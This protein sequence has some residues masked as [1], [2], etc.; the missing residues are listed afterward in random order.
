MPTSP[1]TKVVEHLRKTVLWQEEDHLSDGQLLDRF[2]EMRDHAAFAALVRRHGP[3]VWGVCL[4]IVGHADD[5]EDA[6]QAAFLILV[7]KAAAVKP[8]EAVGN[9]LYGVAA[10]AALKA[11]TA[12]ARVRAKE[13]Q[14]IGMPDPAQVQHDDRE[15]LLRLLD[16]ELGVLPDKYRLPVVLCDLEGRTRKEV[17][18]QLKIPEGT[19]SS[20]LTTAHQKLAKRLARNGLA[21]SGASLAC[22]LA[23]NAASASVPPA[24]VSATINAATLVAAGTGVVAG[25]VSTKVAALTEGVLKTMLLTKLK[26]VAAVLLVVGMFASGAGGLLTYKFATAQQGQSAETKKGQGAEAKKQEEQR[27]LEQAELEGTWSLISFEIN[28]K[29]QPLSW[30]RHEWTFKD[31]KAELRRDGQENE[32]PADRF[33][34]ESDSRFPVRPKRRPNEN[35]PE[36]TQFLR[37]TV[38]PSKSPKELN[39]SYDDS[40]KMLYVYK[41]EKDTL[42]LVVLSDTSVRPEG[43][44]LKDALPS[45]SREEV[46]VEVYERKRIPRAAEPAWGDAVD[47]VRYGISLSNA[48]A[49]I[50]LG[51]EIQFAF[52]VQNKNAK[53]VKLAPFAMYGW[54]AKWPLT[55]D[56]VPIFTNANGK[57]IVG[58]WNTNKKESSDELAL[59]AGETRELG[60][61]GWH[62][63]PLRL[64]GVDLKPGKY[65]VHFERLLV[66]TP[67][68]TGK[69]DIEV[70]EPV[71]DNLPAN[72]TAWGQAVEGIEYGLELKDKRK[73]YRVG[74]TASFILKARNVAGKRASFEYGVNLETPSIFFG[75]PLPTVIDAAGKEVEVS[76]IGQWGANENTRTV[77]LSAGQVVVV[78]E[79][80]FVIGRAESAYVDAGPGTY[81]VRYDSFYPYKS[82]QQPTGTL[83]IVVIEP[84]PKKAA[85]LTARIVAP[86]E[87]ASTAPQLKG[88][89]VLTN[90]GD[91]AVRVCTLCS[92]GPLFDFIF[93][94]H[95]WKSDS[96]SLDMS[97]QRVVMLAPGKSVALPFQINRVHYKDRDSLTIKASYFVDK[98]HDLCKKLNLW[99]GSAE[100]KPALV[101][102]LT[103]PEGLT[104]TAK[105]QKNRV[106]ANEDFKVDLRVV[107]SSK[108]LQS[109]RVMR[110]GSWQHWQ[111]SNKPVSVVALPVLEHFEETVKL[112]PGDAY[113]ETLWVRLGD[114]KPQE[115]VSFKL[116]FTPINSKQTF[117]SDEIS[118]EVEQGKKDPHFVPV[119]S[120]PSE[121]RAAEKRIRELLDAAK[122]TFISVGSRGLTASVAEDKAKQARA[123][124]EKAVK[125][126]TLSVTVLDQ[127]P[128]PKNLRAVRMDDKL[129]IEED[130]AS[131]EEVIVPVA[132]GLI[133]STDCELSVYRGKERVRHSG[134]TY[135]RSFEITRA[136][137]KIPN[138]G[139]SYEVELVINWF[140]T[141]AP[142]QPNWKP[143][144][145]AKYKVLV[146]RTLKLSVGPENTKPAPIPPK[147]DDKPK[148]KGLD[149]AARKSAFSSVQVRGQ[150]VFA[151]SPSGLF[152]A[153]L[154]D[155]QWTRLPTPGSRPISKS[156]AAS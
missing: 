71:K 29:K 128:V 117:W 144:S 137:S 47:G 116:G 67:S 23:Q 75:V 31:G 60:S 5:A 102:V 145:G 150:E 63:D 97:T 88:E 119:A 86:E 46:F 123:I 1:V 48:K 66:G 61:I 57:T 136:I 149:E 51:D 34:S 28:E 32:D 138:P 106:R 103:P 110:G 27:K 80:R 112:D 26:T 133:R 7:R 114:A 105:S 20:R 74:D 98:D 59:K 147:A 45:G 156:F 125:D 17:A 104:V 76:Q 134:G 129:R 91:A 65:T 151:A 56:F 155:K 44:T 15:E 108:S 146:T 55:D 2:V 8:R 36:P 68:P 77:T 73:T 72:K 38:D 153:T 49:R 12:S 96:P 4:R 9:W 107:N 100:A 10:H 85:G 115:K 142:I 143:Q 83:E 84:K 16:Q 122:I 37:F 21:V 140:E 79:Y 6:F 11:R 152:R 62:L 94:P 40:G 95:Q 53:A 25:V 69:I 39:L 78:S 127:L 101:K 18:A 64:R 14:V 131:I 121:D 58:S 82:R 19:L 126:G 130:P 118:V 109:V 3:M 30:K 89:L 139:E 120:Y 54:D 90:E 124:L 33:P 92:E 132:A 113:E 135:T 99:S 154:K 52:H 70:V 43:F 42:T 50:A 24:V 13:K 81:R 93:C 22:L 111:S 141:D 35:Q 148:P 87:I 41:L